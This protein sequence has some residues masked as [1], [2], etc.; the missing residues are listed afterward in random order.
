LKK[1][2]EVDEVA[3]GDISWGQ[4]FD[5]KNIFSEKIGE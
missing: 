3:L 2:L 1:Y 5:V 4:C